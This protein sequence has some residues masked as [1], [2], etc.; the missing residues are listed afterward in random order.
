ME[1]LLD[2]MPCGFLRLAESGGGAILRTNA[3]FLAMLGYA[4]GELEG[5]GVD[6]FLSTE[7][8]SFW[9]TDFL[10][11][12]ALRGEADGIY[13]SLL[14]KQGETVPVLVNAV[15]RETDGEAF[16]DCSARHGGRCP[17][18]WPHSPPNPPA[19][20]RRSSLGIGQ[21]HPV[22]ARYR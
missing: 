2:L 11:L 9:Q 19:A 10:P 13:L 5:L 6:A 16:I 3:T 14:D 17:G 20:P 1:D 18:G 15:R 4:A 22:W 21:I 12:L 7:A 8:R